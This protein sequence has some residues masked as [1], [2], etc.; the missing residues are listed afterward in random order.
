MR[1]SSGYTATYYAEILDAES[2]RGIQ[3][4]E[5]PSGKIS[6]TG[7]GLRQ[8]ADID[9]R[10]VVG[11]KY[12]RI[13]MDARQDGGDAHEALFTGLTSQPEVEWTGF[14]PNRSLA[15]YSVLKAADDIQLQRG[16]YAPAGVNAGMMIQRLLQATPAPVEIIGS[17]PD[18]STSIVAEDGETHVTMVD[19]ILLATGYRMRILGDGTIQIR[20]YDTDAFQRFSIADNDSIEPRI[21]VTDDWFACPNVYQ[22]IADDL[23][24]IVRD[25][26]PSSFLSVPNRGREVWMTE[27]DC[28]LA[29]NESIG[30]YAW[31]RL[32]EEQSRAFV[33][34]YDR[35]YD[36]ALL[37]GDVVELSYPSIGISG[38][39]RIESQS[40]NLGHNATTSEEV[41]AVE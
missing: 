5:I 25:D 14:V 30:Q 36:P 12:I 39:Y 24:A 7:D 32:K 21:T 3:R 17:M 31:R 13:W 33:V 11:E 40:I 9:C 15:C 2:W 10:E 41:V 28:D 22:A 37:V 23:T 16:W 38:K 6:R 1:W 8:S 18:L 34:E 27:S 35:R 26:D 4:F 20:P 19:K 29:D